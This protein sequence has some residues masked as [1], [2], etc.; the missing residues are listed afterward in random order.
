M[1]PISYRD[2]WA[3]IS[4]D[5][6]KHNFLQF[7]QFVKQPTKI[8]A[9]VKADGYG[10]GAVEIAKTSIQ[11]GADYLAVA[12]LDEAI[13]LRESGIS[14]PILVLGYTPTRSVE[15]AILQ[16]VTLTVFDHELMDEIIVKSSLLH[17]KASI[18]LK[19]DTGMSRIGVASPEEALILA[20]K[21]NAA[22]HVHLE[23]IFTHFASAD[24]EDSTFTDEQF[25]KFQLVLDFLKVHSIHIPLQHCCNSAAT[26][27]FP[28]MHL[29]MVRI[30]VALYGLYPDAS[31]KKLP[32]QLKQAMSFKTRIAA[33]K[34]VATSQTV[35]YGCTWRPKQESIIATVPLGY[36]DGL[37]RQLSNRGSVLIH[38]KKAMIAGRVCMDQ[39]M[40]DITDFPHCTLGDEVVIFGENQSS[41]QSVDDIAELMGTINY[42]VVC[43]IGKRVPRVFVDTSSVFELVGSSR[44]TSLR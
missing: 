30:G 22:T 19:V 35:S 2:T 42:E 8:M 13:K 23:G 38:G 18:H 33:I 27:K 14:E 37:S 5:D 16:N 7:R 17:K 21:A 28:K 10:H 11:M 39:T 29:D 26:M 9:V 32:I 36:A 25:K 43:L 44:A 4:L 1:K 3:E 34:K 6:I 41:F 40:I 15:E 12:L 31:L 20:T 24:S